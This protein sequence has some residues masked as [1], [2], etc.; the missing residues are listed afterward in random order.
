MNV[1]LR[2][3]GRSAVLAI[4][5]VVMAPPSARAQLQEGQTVSFT[6]RVHAQWNTTSAPDAV[7]SEFLIRRARITADVG[8]NDLVSGRVQPEFVEDDVQL[9]DAYVKL[10][11][12]P[13]FEMT[14]GQFKRP[15]DLFTLESS[16]RSLTIERA[17]KIRGAGDCPGVG[18]IC[19][20]SRF[21]EKLNYSDR[22]IG[23]RFAGALG[24]GP[25]TYAVSL[26]NGEG[27]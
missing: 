7:D 13:Y 23:V 24:D 11:F 27:A 3:C 14:M 26:T 16:T 17:G 10:S 19:S 25:L 2:V 20:Y 5:V 4:L 8:V 6:G 18:G 12:S 9:R 22:D 15:F 21:T 1:G